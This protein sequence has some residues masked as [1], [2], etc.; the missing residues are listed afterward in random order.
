MNKWWMKTWMNE[1][2]PNPPHQSWKYCPF[3]LDSQGT[4]FFFLGFISVNL[5]WSVLHH[6]ILLQWG[7]C[8]LSE[9]LSWG[10]KAGIGPVLHVAGSSEQ[11]SDLKPFPLVGWPFALGFQDSTLGFP[12]TSLAT[13]SLAGTSL[14]PHLLMLECPRAQALFSYLLCNTFSYPPTQV[15]LT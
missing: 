12:P 3:L 5:I 2:D 6:C 4:V 9:R 10:L 15:G 7:N 1:S 14:S 8:D 13:L 11:V